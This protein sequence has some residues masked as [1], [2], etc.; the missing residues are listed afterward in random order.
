MVIIDTSVWID[1]F[2]NAGTPQC[3][4]LDTEVERQRLGLTDLILCEILSGLRDE[5]QANETKRSAN[6]ISS[7]S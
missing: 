1:Y 7:K 3:N 5:K 2:N 4:R 6:C